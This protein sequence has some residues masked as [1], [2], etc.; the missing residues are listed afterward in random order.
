MT[1][2]WAIDLLGAILPFGGLKWK[3]G[4]VNL[5]DS[6]LAIS[7]FQ[8]L[9]SVPRRAPEVL[10]NF[11]A[12]AENKANEQ[13]RRVEPSLCTLNLWDPG[14]LRTYWPL[15]ALKQILFCPVFLVV[16]GRKTYNL[17]MYSKLIYHYKKQKFSKFNFF[18]W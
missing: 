14:S 6:F 1:G 17:F 11:L 2:G 8:I 18:L 5:D 13:E 3:L 7:R 4:G 9:T 10:L 12:T 15:N 16:L